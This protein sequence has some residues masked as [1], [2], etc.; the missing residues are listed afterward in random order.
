MLDSFPVAICDHIRIPKARLLRSEDYRGYIA[1]KK[2]YFY[3]IR[4]QLRST[5]SGIPL[6]F[7]FLPGAANDIRGLHALPLNL[8][9]KSEVYADSAYRDYQAEDALKLTDEI[10]LKVL[11]KKNSHRQD[12]PWINFYKQATRHIIETVF[13]EI[14]QL[15]P[16]SIHAVTFYG[17]LLKVTTFILALTLKKA[18]I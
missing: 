14:N 17:F 7:I 16:K 8:P 13:S 18:F 11:R 5:S 2:R 1:S 4:V 15:F 10:D 9:P 12:A 6:E 3:G